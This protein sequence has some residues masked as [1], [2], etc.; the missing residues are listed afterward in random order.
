M[1]K[2]DVSSVL[3]TIDAFVNPEQPSDVQISN[4]NNIILRE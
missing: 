4:L 1:E 2:A 3:A